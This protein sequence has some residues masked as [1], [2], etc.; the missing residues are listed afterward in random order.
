MSGW[1]PL[2]VHSHYSL[3]QATPSPEA[4]ARQAAAEGLTHL[5]LTD[6]HAL[7]GVVAFAQACRRHHVQ[8]V[9]GMTIHILN[10][11]PYAPTPSMGASPPGTLV[12]LAQGVEGYRNLCRLSA[13]LHRDPQHHPQATSLET[14]AQHAAGLLCITGGHCLP[15]GGAELPG[16]HGDEPA[17]PAP[18]RGGL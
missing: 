8:P 9:I 4:L 12:L 16:G 10:D 2:H 18:G 6:T 5:A 17:L 3:L 13:Q 7:Y 1:V 11:G 15:A 14:L